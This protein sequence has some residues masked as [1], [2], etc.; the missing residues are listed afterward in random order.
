MSK[1]D[2]YEKH[3]SECI[4]AKIAPML[5]TMLKAID[6][7]VEQLNKDIS[8]LK[9]TQIGFYFIFFYKHVL[10]FKEFSVYWK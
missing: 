2:D 5:Q 10:C 6:F 1:A 8:E 3:L 9:T 4:C 7:K